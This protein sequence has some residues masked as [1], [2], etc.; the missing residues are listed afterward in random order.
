MIVGPLSFASNLCTSFDNMPTIRIA[1]A[2]ARASDWPLSAHKTK[3]RS[4]DQ[5][6]GWKGVIRRELMGRKPARPCIEDEDD[7]VASARRYQSF[8]G[9]RRARKKR[10]GCEESHGT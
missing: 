8:S 2:T 3:R 9:I 7:K 4:G 5:R 10:M 1:C 6:Y